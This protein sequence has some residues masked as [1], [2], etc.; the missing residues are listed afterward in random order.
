[1]DTTHVNDGKEDTKLEDDGNQGNGQ[2][3]EDILMWREGYGQHSDGVEGL[4]EVLWVLDI[5]VSP[6]E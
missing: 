5:R 2:A 1:M 4:T 6:H 3:L